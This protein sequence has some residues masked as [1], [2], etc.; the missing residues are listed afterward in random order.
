[1]AIDKLP[2]EIQVRLGDVVVLSGEIQA[3][4]T[5]AN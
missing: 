2:I 1:V 4:A 5:P 3:E